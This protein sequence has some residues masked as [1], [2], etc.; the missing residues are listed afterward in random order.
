MAKN[1]QCQ[2]M[3]TETHL[4]SSPEGLLE[5]GTTSV[6]SMDTGLHAYCV[7]L[8][9]SKTPYCAHK[10]VIA[11][12]YKT[13]LL[14]TATLYMYLVALYRVALLWLFKRHPNAGPSDINKAEIRGG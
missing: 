5:G 8:F 1:G 13:R 2:V 7:G 9:R 14:R 11:C 12:F 10:W 3:P 6:A 4:L